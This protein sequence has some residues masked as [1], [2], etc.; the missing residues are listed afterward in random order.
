MSHRAN[1]TLT[2][3]IVPTRREVLAFIALADA[4]TPHTITLDRDE[5]EPLALTLRLRTS[6]DLF[7][8]LPLFGVEMRAIRHAEATTS[9]MWYHYAAQWRGRTLRL[10]AEDPIPAPVVEPLDEVTRE[11][12][13]AVAGA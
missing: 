8:W 4:P 9:G 13:T 3:P 10:T 11:Q 2:K 1:A 6:A 5:Y 7:V 12:L